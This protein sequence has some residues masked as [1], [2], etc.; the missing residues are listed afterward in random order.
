MLNKL[1][2]EVYDVRAMG[3]AVYGYAMVA[4]GF[5]DAYITL[6]TY[7]WDIAAGALIVEEAS[8]KVTDFNG[9]TWKA[10]IGKY[11]ATNNKIHNQLI[12]VL[13]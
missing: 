5:V 8:G 7:P 3:S 4:R 6:Y 11:I 12:K 9:N 2:G 1:K 10:K 13:R